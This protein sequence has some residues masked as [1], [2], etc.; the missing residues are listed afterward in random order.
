MGQEITAV[1]LENTSL[2][3]SDVLEIVVER[4]FPVGAQSTTLQHQVVQQL[5][6]FITKPTHYEI[7]V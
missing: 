6:L 4:F 2:L 1:K 3:I 5:I 7:L